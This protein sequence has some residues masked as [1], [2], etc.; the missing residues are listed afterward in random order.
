MK[1]ESTVYNRP[2]MLLSVTL[3]RLDVDLTM[4]TNNRWT[5]LVF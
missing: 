1:D 4:A 5:R 3:T 2:F